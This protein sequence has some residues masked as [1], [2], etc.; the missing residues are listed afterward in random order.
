MSNIIVYYRVS[1]N[2]Q[3]RSGLGLEAQRAAVKQYVERTGA[4]LLTSYKEI[5]SGTKADR[6]QL[7]RALAHAARS[8]ATLVVAKLDRLSRN[9][10]FLDALQG[11]KVNFCALDCEFASKP[12]LQ[13]MPPQQNLWVFSG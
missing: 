3:E 9:L 1:T 2:G 8:R 12:M 5:E 13:I 6:P 11:A 4:N 10:A 7:A